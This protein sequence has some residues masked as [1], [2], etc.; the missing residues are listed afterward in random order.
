MGI[1]AAI[2]G[3]FTFFHEIMGIVQL[4]QKT[5]EEKRRDAIGAIHA[6]IKKANETRGDTSDEEDIFR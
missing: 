5:P 6:A 3:F 4:L 1:V 2:T